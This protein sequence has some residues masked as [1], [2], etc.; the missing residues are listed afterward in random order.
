MSTPRIE[1]ANLLAGEISALLVAADLPKVIVSL[2][3]RNIPSG[4]RDG[5]VVIMP[6]D[7]DFPTFA[8]TEAS[9]E[10][11]V[12]AGTVGNLLAAWEILDAIIEA[13]RPLNLYGSLDTATADMFA[14]KDSPQLPGYT[15]KLH[16]V[17]VIVES[18]IP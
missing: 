6:P 8:E 3:I 2:D 11:A 15:V 5:I 13:L 17:S 16:P 9:H 14:P 18:E 7:L 1:Y 12:V 4:A 10:L